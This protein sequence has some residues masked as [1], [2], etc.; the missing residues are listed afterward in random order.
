MRSFWIDIKKEEDGVRIEV[1][2]GTETTGFMSRF[3][4]SNPYNSWPPTY[5][6]FGAWNSK[7]DYK[8]CLKQTGN[9]NMFWTQ[10]MHVISVHF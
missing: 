2:K 6:A 4:E 1:G 10:N 8:F 9:L 7:V 3:W 5:V